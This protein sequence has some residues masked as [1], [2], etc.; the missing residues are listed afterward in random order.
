VSSS[1][2]ATVSPGEVDL[3]MHSTASDGSLPP[4]QVVQAAHA[5]GLA[6]I[7]LT[8]HDTLAGLAEATAEGGALGV[9]VVPAVEL[10]AHDGNREIHI[11]ALHISDHPLI[12]GRLSG[13]RQ[14]R[15]T[16]A[17][18]IVQRLGQMKI[19]VPLEM[20]MEE[21]AGGAVGRPHIARA[22]VR[23][24][25]VSDQREAFD[26]YLAAGRPGFV[27]KERL[28]IREAIELAHAAGGLAIWAHP[29]TEGRRARVEPLVA[30]GLDG[31][32]VLH[33]SHKVEDIK[34]LGALADFFGVVASGGSDWHGYTGGYR[35][36]GCMHVPEAWLSIQD[37]LVARRSSGAEAGNA[38]GR[39]LPPT[40][41]TR[42]SDVVL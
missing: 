23:T 13:F 17:A 8:D 25:I 1:V 37:Q 35:S 39:D 4:S 12:E 18:L 6:A 22:M 42:E 2:S 34:R 9:R 7:A 16:R 29:G 11:L 30:L 38:P 20:V 27:E 19:D 41:S 26:Q 33:P 14:A 28:E 21:A 10:S 31:L 3:H 5:A 32:E 36:I 15:E 24:G 40:S